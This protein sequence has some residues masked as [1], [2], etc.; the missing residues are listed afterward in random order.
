MRVLELG[1]YIAP[2]YAGMILGEQG[3]YVQ[4]W[5]N[6]PNT[7]PVFDLYRGDELWSWLN[8]DKEIVARHPIEVKHTRR[9]DVVIDNFKPSTLATWHIDPAK[10]AIEHNLVWVSLRSEVGETSFDILAQARS[11]AEYGPYIPFYIGDTSAGLWMAF[12]ATAMRIPGH[13]V[14]GHASC[15]QKLV[16]GELIIDEPR[17]GIRVPWDRDAYFY[18]G[19]EAIVEYRGKQFV[20]PTRD[21]EWKL[22]HLWHKNGR[23]TI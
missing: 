23:I 13:Y 21:R 16:E 8:A 7:D 12:K 11:T 17:N 4:K 6:E 3:H 1:N 9:F 15:L 10:I 20:E 22:D 2:A 19:N 14:I 5:V 18:D